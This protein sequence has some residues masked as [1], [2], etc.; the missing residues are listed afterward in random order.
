MI[1]E[2]SGKCVFVFLASCH[3]RRFIVRWKIYVGHEQVGKDGKD[4][5]AS[6]HRWL[7]TVCSATSYGKLYSFAVFFRMVFNKL[8]GAET[9]TEEKIPLRQKVDKK[10]IGGNSLRTEEAFKFWA[11]ALKVPPQSRSTHWIAP[12]GGAILPKFDAHGIINQSVWQI[13][14]VIEAICVPR[15][16]PVSVN[17]LLLGNRCCCAGWLMPCK[18]SATTFQRQRLGP[19]NLSWKSL[20]FIEKNQFWSFYRW[21]ATKTDYFS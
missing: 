2:N 19:R 10:T 13:I 7:G 6:V 21:N 8:V 1:Q 4:A 16:F 14:P 18:R 17:A 9:R 12:M 3:H 15:V 20:I 11:S 5:N